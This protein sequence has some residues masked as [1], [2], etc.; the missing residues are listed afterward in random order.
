MG[1]KKEVTFE[2]LQKQELLSVLLHFINPISPTRKL[3]IRNV[4][5][6]DQCTAAVKWY[7]FIYAELKSMIFYSACQNDLRSFAD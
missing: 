2:N 3:K 1:E 5:K 6:T 4:R 7:N